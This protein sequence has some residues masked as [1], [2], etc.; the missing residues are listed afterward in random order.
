K[1][2]SGE[3]LG[4]IPRSFA[5]HLAFAPDG[6]TLA[7]VNGAGAIRLWDAATRKEVRP[8]EGHHGEVI[9]LAFSPDGNALLSETHHPTLPSAS[10][11]RA[12]RWWDVKTGKPT[13]EFEASSGSLRGCL[14]LS[15]DGKLFTTMRGIEPTIELR[16]AKTGKTVRQLQGHRGPVSQVVFSPDGK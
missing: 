12:V 2:P 11:D 9:G 14:A 16:D 1:V 13:C 10:Q 5:Q 4:E 3:R 6:K 15:P 8:T 7:T